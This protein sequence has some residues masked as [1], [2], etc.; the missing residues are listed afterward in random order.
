MDKY[1]TYNSTSE[2]HRELTNILLLTVEDNEH[3]YCY[4]GEEF[5]TCGVCGLAIFLID[6]NHENLLEGI[7]P[8]KFLA[9]NYNNKE[10][11][12][13]F[14]L[15]IVHFFE[16]IK[17]ENKSSLEFF[18]RDYCWSLKVYSTG[19]TLS[20]NLDEAIENELIDMRDETYEDIYS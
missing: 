18:Q 7:S 6:P 14:A 15:K 19:E 17:K 12:N 3:F 10:K 8:R 11:L 2:L 13:L 9:R 1:I 5:G 4:C 20:I 16:K